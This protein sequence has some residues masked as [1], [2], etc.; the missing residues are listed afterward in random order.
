MENRKVFK[1]SLTYLPEE[2]SKIL[3]KK[4]EEE[5]KIVEQYSSNN[6]ILFEENL[7][8]QIEYI[9]GKVNVTSLFSGA[10]GLDLGVKL[11]GI[12]AKYGEQKAYKIFKDK[13]KFQKYSSSINIMYSNDLFKSANETYLSNF[14][15]EGVQDDRDIRKVSN[16]PQSD[17]MLGGFPCPGFSSAGPRLLDDPRNFLYIHYIRALSQARPAF[18]IAENVKGILTMA[19]GQV[20][21]QIKEDFSAV[22]YQVSAYLVNA[23]D[24]GVPQSRE[25]VFIIGVRKD[26]INEYNFQYELPEDTHGEGKIKYATL[27]DAI[28]D[29]PLNANDVFTSNYSSMYMSRNRKKGW[30]EPSFTIQAS[31]RQAP[32]HP[33]GNPMIKLDKDLWRFSGDFNRRLSVREA[34]RIQ[35]FPD[36]FMFSDGS[37]PNVS[38]NN[39][40][41]EQYKQIGNAV[42]SILAE[43]ISRPII[44]FLVDHKELLE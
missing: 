30:D 26:I 28:E 7:L 4:I 5:N 23:K 8:Q 16:F 31:G 43:K 21:E 27:R 13:K 20:I 33:A 40:L 6:I 38:K 35:T 36:W 19:K 12:S 29:L 25:R 41:N 22:G 10:G 24:Y 18:F 3:H 11:A 17:L 1:S 9:P 32:Q 37:N 15:N 42:P 14:G 2:V 39:R 44:E 34:A